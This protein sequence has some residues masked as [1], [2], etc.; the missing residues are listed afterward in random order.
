MREKVAIFELRRNEI[1]MSLS[2]S[3]Q[4]F[5]FLKQH[6]ENNAKQTD[7]F[8]WTSISRFILTSHWSKR[9]PQTETDG[10]FTLNLSV[11]K[12]CLLLRT[13]FNIE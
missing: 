2:P 6:L 5:I 11:E 3:N 12:F 9:K 4:I 1:G 8:F 10:K 7:N 13:I